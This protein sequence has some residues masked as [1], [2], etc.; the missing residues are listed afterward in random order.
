[1]DGE[2]GLESDVTPAGGLTIDE[3]TSYLTIAELPI[4]PSSS[5]VPSVERKFRKPVRITA[6]LMT[7][8]SPP[9][10]P[11]P[12]QSVTSTTPQSVAGEKSVQVTVTLLTKKPGDDSF[13]PLIDDSNNR[14][15]VQ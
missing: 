10:S 8:R 12:S 1:M 7:L 11:A 14:P 13:T 6:L 5:E 4:D 9:S 2:E 3:A 15:K